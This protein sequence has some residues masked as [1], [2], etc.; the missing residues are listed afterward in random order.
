MDN[1]E[2]K[3]LCFNVV[4]WIWI[5][6]L[7][8]FGVSKFQRIS[9]FTVC[10]VNKLGWVRPEIV[11]VIRAPSLP[12]S[13]LWV[14]R[15]PYAILFFTNKLQQCFTLLNFPDC[16]IRVSILMFVQFDVCFLYR[17]IW[18]PCDWFIKIYKKEESYMY[19]L[20]LGISC[21][22]MVTRFLAKLIRTLI[23]KLNRLSLILYMSKLYTHD[24]ILLDRSIN[25][26]RQLML[27]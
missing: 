16:N 14:A 26:Q 8:A 9:W 19:F 23:S 11:Q 22:S 18:L 25:Q 12:P 3:I 4:F 15:G 2:N 7:F 1:V 10:C 24:L 6:V 17:L 20:G 27:W 5:V 13:L 21:W